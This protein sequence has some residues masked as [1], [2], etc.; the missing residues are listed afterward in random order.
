MLSTTQLQNLYTDLTGNTSTANQ[1][2]GLQFI[3][4]QHRYLLQKYFNNETTYSMTTVG[5]QSKTLTGT[6]GIGDISA[7]LTASWTFPTTMVPVTFSSSEIRL[8]QFEKGSTSIKWSAALTAV[9]TTAITTGGLQFYPLPPNYSKMKT[10]TI[11]VGQLK[12]TPT[13]IF[14]REDWDNLNVFP[15]NSDIPVNFFIYDNQVGIWPIPSTT[16]NVISFN[17]KMRVPDLSIADYS[18]GTASVTT[19]TTAVTGATTV[20][21]PTTNFALES[22]W[23][24]FPQTAGDNLWYQIASVDSTT[25]L[26]LMNNYQGITIAAGNYTVGQMPLIAEDFHD[27]LVWKALQQYFSSIGDN[28]EKA[29]EYGELYND[30]LQLFEEFAGRKTIQVNLR[31]DTYPK[32]PNLFQSN[33]G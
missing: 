32:N 33:I 24:Q 13:E 20:W 17:Y 14:T 28:P 31:T 12:W 27:M 6:P 4:F 15:Y 16:G 11:N 26:T 1:T 30:R 3:N 2:R 19:G 8:V 23:I 18:V 9:A 22:R 21:T 29:K 7:T 25:A 10:V 5:Q